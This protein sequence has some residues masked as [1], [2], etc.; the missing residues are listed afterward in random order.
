MCF[1]DEEKRKE[2]DTYITVCESSLD[3]VPAPSVQG[4]SNHVASSSM[5]GNPSI[6]CMHFCL[7]SVLVDA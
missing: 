3:P 4:H 6:R 7:K 2:E 5:N 1:A